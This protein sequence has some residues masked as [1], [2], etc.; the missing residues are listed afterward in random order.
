[1]SATVAS[2]VIR[3]WGPVV[4]CATGLTGTA[5]GLG[6]LALPNRHVAS[7]IA[8]LAGGVYYC[9]VPLYGPTIP[10]MLLRCVPAHR[11]GAVMGLDGAINTV[12]RVISPVAMGILYSRNGPSWAF[13][14]ASL[15]SVAAA[16]VTLFRRWLVIRDN[17]ALE[18]S[19]D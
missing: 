6:L 3:L 16:S 4:A 5:A 15:A 9:G 2:R 1:M 7:W 17:R 10:T 13:G 12:A 18:K 8:L 14:V 19:T 11:R